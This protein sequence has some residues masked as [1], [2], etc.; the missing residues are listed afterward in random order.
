VVNGRVWASFIGSLGK[1]SGKS[2]ADSECVIK[3]SVMK[4]KRG[5][6][7]IGQSRLDG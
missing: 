3:S 2:I 7:E 6:G 1:K 5:E 4:L